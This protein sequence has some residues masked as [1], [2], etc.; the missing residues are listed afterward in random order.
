[1]GVYGAIKAA[2]NSLTRSAAVEWAPHGIR[3]NAV[4]PGLTATPLIDA[5]VGA[6][7]DPEEFLARHAA[8][9]PQGR[10]ARPEEVA[11]LVVFLAGDEAAHLTGAVVPIDGGYTAQ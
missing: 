1:M 10:L 4:A 9:I 3:V 5:W 2:V 7:D 6:Q 8:T 11:A